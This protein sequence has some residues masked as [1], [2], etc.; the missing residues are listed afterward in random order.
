MPPGQWGG[1]AK[2][3]GD[4]TSAGGE[5]G[6]SEEGDE[7]MKCRLGEDRGEGMER[8]LG[9]G[10][11]DYRVPFSVGRLGSVCNSPCYRRGGPS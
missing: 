2:D 5:D 7:P 10:G 6:R 8:W 4:G 1:G 11:Y 9:F 3:V